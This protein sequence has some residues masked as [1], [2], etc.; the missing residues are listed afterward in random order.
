MTRC[1]FMALNIS[2]NSVLVFDLDDT[3]YKEIEFLKSAF[4][5]IGKVLT[6]EIGRDVSKEMIRRYHSGKEVFEWIIENHRVQSKSKEE[7]IKIYRDH[8]PDIHLST[9]VAEKL[10][11][12]KNKEM[13]TGLITDGRSQTQRNKLKSLGLENYFDEVLISEEF[14]S[15]K[16][17]VKNFKYMQQKL[18]GEPFFYISDNINK[19]FIAP[20]HLSWDTICLADDGSNIHPQDLS[21]IKDPLYRPAHLISNFN[22]INVDVS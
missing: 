1:W 15:E 21:A 2:S 4:L 18:Q 7:L 22:E 10:K 13:A 20:N 17:D 9:E 14:G 6:D 12:I 5:E 11:E 16:P 8:K 3:L 19:D